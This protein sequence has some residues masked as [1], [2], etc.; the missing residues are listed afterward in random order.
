MFGY[1]GYLRSR[2]EETEGKRKQELGSIYSSQD[3]LL[4]KQLVQA[5]SWGDL[6]IEASKVQLSNL[7]GIVI[8]QDDACFQ[9]S[10]KKQR[11]EEIG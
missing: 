3:G 11:S 9:P 10:R 6:H 5:L 8:Q 1:L 2:M 4:D 7:T